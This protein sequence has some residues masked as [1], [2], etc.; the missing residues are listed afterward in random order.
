M[1]VENPGQLPDYEIDP[2]EIDLTNSIEI[3]KVLYSYHHFVSV[4]FSM[5]YCR[6]ESCF[7]PIVNKSD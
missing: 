2:K 3:A 7:V 4:L 5:I 6:R 1:R